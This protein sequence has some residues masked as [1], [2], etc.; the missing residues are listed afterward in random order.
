MV[1]FG[2]TSPGGK[3]LRSFRRNCVDCSN[4]LHVLKDPLRQLDLRRE[5][6]HLG[7]ARSQMHCP[8]SLRRCSEHAWDQH[9]ASNWQKRVND[10]T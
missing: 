3:N 6:V 4:M 10:V 5:V 7:P 9:R 8:V 2:K 1:H